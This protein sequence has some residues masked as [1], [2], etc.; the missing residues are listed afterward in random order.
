MGL[1]GLLLLP[2]KCKRNKYN[3]NTQTK[4]ERRQLVPLGNNKISRNAIVPAI[5][6]ERK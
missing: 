3:E 5:V 2:F 1:H 4:D 6:G